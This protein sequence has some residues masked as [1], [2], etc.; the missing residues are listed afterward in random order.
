MKHRKLA[1]GL[2]LL[3][4]AI[5]PNS[6]SPL[7]KRNSSSQPDSQSRSKTFRVLKE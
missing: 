5:W 7:A 4:V 2:A 1:I 6:Q 3:A